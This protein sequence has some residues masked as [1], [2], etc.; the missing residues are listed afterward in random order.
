MIQ[1]TLFTPPIYFID[2]STSKFS[3]SLNQFK[4][5]SIFCPFYLVS[6][7]FWQ[8]FIKILPCALAEV[9]SST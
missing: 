7:R 9:K 8:S 4:T 3:L 1:V 5:K 6:Q 2:H